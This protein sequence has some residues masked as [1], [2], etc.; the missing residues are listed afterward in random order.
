M[1]TLPVPEL[2]SF[3]SL[4]RHAML[5]EEHA[6]AACKALPGS[7]FAELAIRHENRLRLLERT[8]REKLSE[9]ML[10]PIEGLEG[11]DYVPAP[12][13]EGLPLAQELEILSARFY[14]DSARIARMVLAEVSRIFERL[15]QE[16]DQCL[17]ELKG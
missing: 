2:N 13:M 3:G 16:N 17:Q 5:L 8:R 10:E 14:R 1:T 7:G 12:N 4:V 15:A 6:A 11:A 9:I